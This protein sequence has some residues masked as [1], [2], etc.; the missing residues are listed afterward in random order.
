ML[1]IKIVSKDFDLNENLSEN[2]LRSVL[3]AEFEYLIDHDFPKLVQIL[4]K[5]DVDQYQVKTLLE[6]AEGQSAA[7]IITEVYIKRQLAKVET[8]KKYSK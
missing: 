4:Y 5:A 8:W 3:V 6:N 1:L 2:D 7:D